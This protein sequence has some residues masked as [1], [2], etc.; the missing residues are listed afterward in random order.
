MRIETPDDDLRNRS[1]IDDS[2]RRGAIVVDVDPESAAAD[3]GLS[4]GDLIVEVAHQPLK[5]SQEAV[6][7]LNR[8]RDSSGVLLLRVV[9]RQGTRFIAVELETDQ[10]G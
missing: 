10:Q 8:V 7:V 6:R 3:A 2:Q 5:S 1:G 4:K 9:G